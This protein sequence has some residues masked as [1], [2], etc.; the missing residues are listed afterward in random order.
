VFPIHT[1]IKVKIKTI[2]QNVQHLSQTIII[3]QKNSCKY[4][5]ICEKNTTI[6]WSSFEG[7]EKI[8]RVHANLLTNEKER[9]G[10]QSQSQKWTYI[11]AMKTQNKVINHIKW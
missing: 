7:G 4:I 9:Q 8:I 2:G 10:Q 3:N 11:E 1:Y 6:I 5:P